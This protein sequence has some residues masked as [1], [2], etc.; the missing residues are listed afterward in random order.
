MVNRE[1]RRGELAQ[2]KTEGVNGMDE[3]EGGRLNSL[4]GFMSPQ[5]CFGT[6]ID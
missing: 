4:N 2:R 3:K 6:I 5:T 1:E